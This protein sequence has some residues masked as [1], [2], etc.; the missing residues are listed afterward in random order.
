MKRVKK[1]E[2]LDGFIS[3]KR[4]PIPQEYL[5]RKKNF[6]IRPTVILCNE[7]HAI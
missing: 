3:K 2:K 4:K 5:K 6:F 7:Y 1:S